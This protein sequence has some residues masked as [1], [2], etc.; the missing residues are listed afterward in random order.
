MRKIGDE[1][2]RLASALLLV[3]HGDIVCFDLRHC[4]LRWLFTLH[5]SGTTH[6]RRKPYTPSHQSVNKTQFPRFEQPD[7][8]A[9]VNQPA[10]ASADWRIA[11]KR[12]CRVSGS[13]LPH[14]LLGKHH[15]ASCSQFLWKQAVIGKFV[16]WGGDIYRA[17]LP[18]EPFQKSNSLGLPS[19][20]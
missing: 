13:Q 10:A 9:L 17:S 5:F 14:S 4:D 6:A 3:V 2:K 8:E 7:A 11:A 16:Y 15:V 12:S 18:H 19:A 20:I 1:D